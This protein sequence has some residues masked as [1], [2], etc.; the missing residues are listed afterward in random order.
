MLVHNSVLPSTTMTEFNYLLV[1]VLHD[2]LERNKC[3]GGAKNSNVWRE[4]Q[5]PLPTL[6]QRKERTHFGFPLC[7][8]NARTM[9]LRYECAKPNTRFT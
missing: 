3:T 7:V 2:V 4:L 9:K 5:K 6:A 8:L 1:A